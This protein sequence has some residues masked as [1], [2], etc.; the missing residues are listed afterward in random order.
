MTVFVAGAVPRPHARSASED[1]RPGD[2]TCVLLV[3]VVRVQLSTYNLLTKNVNPGTKMKEMREEVF[4]QV[5]RAG[6]IKSVCVV[7]QHGRASIHYVSGDGV[8][9][10]VFTKRGDLKLYR[11]ET[12]L[13]TLRR[14][15]VVVVEID[16]T[17]WTVDGEPAAV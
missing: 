3:Y 2:D 1:V 11:I 12:A 16:M 4:E 15:G 5:Y 6:A 7:V 13:V 10:T 8:Q 9:G 14:A 17:N